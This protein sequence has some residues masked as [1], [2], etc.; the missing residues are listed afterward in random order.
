MSVGKGPGWACSAALLCFLAVRLC[1]GQQCLSESLAD[2]VID[3]QSSL[4]K[5]IRGNEPVHVQ[6]QQDCIR[7]CCSTENISGES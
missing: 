2:V 7:S 5:G 6:T 1:T 3:I 4:S